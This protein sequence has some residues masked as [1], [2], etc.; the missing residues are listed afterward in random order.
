MV[1]SI[2]NTQVKYQT[3]IKKSTKNPLFDET[4][5]FNLDTYQVESARLLVFIYS[6]R[7]LI[8]KNLIGCIIF[9]NTFFLRNCHYTVH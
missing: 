7:I 9:G 8:S 6:K 1:L 4:F 2:E 3:M 5:E